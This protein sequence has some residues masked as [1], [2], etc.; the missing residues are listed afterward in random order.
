MVTRAKFHSGLRYFKTLP[1][2]TQGSKAAFSKKATGIFKWDE[3][4][5]RKSARGF[6]ESEKL[7]EKLLQKSLYLTSP[8]NST[9][10]YVIRRKADS[11]RK[12]R[13]S[14]S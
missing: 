11:R 8:H 2:A 4:D 13:L 12:T 3:T 7:L 9:V 5:F 14:A 1:Q 10:R 6:G